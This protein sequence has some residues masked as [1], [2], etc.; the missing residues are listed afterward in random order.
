[1]SSSTFFVLS[2]GGP[3]VSGSLMSIAV[4]FARGWLEEHSVPP[5][6]GVLVAF[7]VG[8]IATRK[9]IH[10][11]VA[12]HCPKCEKTTAFEMDGIPCRF[13]CHVCSKEF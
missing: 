8:A 9:I 4:W 7:I 5:L 12:V 3:I 13:R 1:M 11:F 2:F 10:S 6:P